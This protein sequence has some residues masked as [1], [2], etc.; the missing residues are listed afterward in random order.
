MALTNL[1]KPQ[2]DQPVFEWMRFAP[3]ATAATSALATSDDLGGRYMYYVNAQAL[4]RY[5]TYS[6][7]WQELAPPPAAPVTGTALKYSKYSGYRGH[8]ISATSNTITLAGF[9]RHAHIPDELKIRIIAGKGAGQERTITE[10]ADAVVA[11]FGL[12]TTASATTIGD[13]TK[14]WKINQWDSYQCRLVYSTGQS[15]IR[16]VLYNDTTTLYFSDTNFQAID[17][18]NNTGFSSVSP[19]AIPVTTAGSQ[20]HF[21]IESTT[22]TIDTA[23][24]VT[25]DQSSIY[26][27]ISGGLWLFS[28]SAGAPFS[29]MQF[30]D[31]LTDTWMTKTPIG[32]HLTAAYG[33]DFSMDRTGEV[34]GAFVSGVTATSAT[35]R[36]LINTG[37][38]M[39]IDRYANH[40]LR[41]V[42]GTGV[43]QRR[44]IVGHGA[45]AMY[46]ERDWDITPDSTS[47]YAIYGD[48]DKI[49]LVGNASS[50]VFGYSIEGDIW[51]N[52]H[53]S[54]WGIA[55]N[56]N[57][58]P[59]AGASYGTPHPGF[60][61]SSIVRTTSGILSGSI[62]AAGT[63]Y[64][65]GDLVTCSTTGTNGQ[66]WVTGVG[67]GGAVTSLEL[68]ASGS[69]YANGSSN[70]TGGS[71]SGLT[72]TLTVG[73]TALVTTATNHDFRTGGGE[74][75]KIAGCATDTSFNTT[76]TIIGVGSLTTFSIA[77]PSSSASPTA[78]NSQSTTL[79]VDAEK[80]W[81][82]NEHT[83]KLVIIQVAGTSPTTQVRRITSNTANTLTVPSIT[84]ATNGT[85][86]YVIQEVRGFGAMCT[87]KIANKAAFGWATSGTATTL[88]DSTKNWNIN[89]Y[90]N[91]KVRIVSGTG[92]G[93]ESTI[94]GNTAT[95]LTVA[96]WG[97]ATP[98]STSKYEILE[99][100]G[101]V[102]TGGSAVATITDANKNW[103]TNILAGKRVRVVAGTGIG[104]E[105]AI[106]SNTA[107]V[108]TCAST[109]TTD[110]T[111]VYEIYEIPARSTG[112]KVDWLFGLSDNAKKGRWLL[113]PRGG[114]SNIFDIYDI[115]SNTWEITPFF[116]PISTTLT[117]GSMY[118]YNG[119]D[120]YYFTKDNTGRLYN[121]NLNTFKIDAAGLTPYA[122]GTAVIGNRMEVVETADG[123]E[124]IYVM[125]HSGFEMWRTLRFW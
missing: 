50:C 68:A 125:R 98:D 28:S 34:G 89:Q 22:C 41:I 48:T 54:D 117:T 1:L 58:T 74:V 112:T 7:S 11:D 5:D 2:V 100:Y 52:G 12:A 114:A 79:L 43:G 39:E 37:A 8:I 62:N 106:T 29:T 108:I 93:N 47:G 92:I 118:T 57:A 30:Y 77:A 65:V 99:T 31:I 101:V 40:Q 76:F 111:T 10:V 4:W 85:G 42:S 94:T 84:A 44:R 20:T 14:K 24:D 82:V 109:L 123:L 110:T 51:S 35:A 75:V 102:T 9:S 96:S 56:I 3:V 83:G 67:S 105:L 32:G 73:T 104:T 21:L 18:F 27:I 78:A 115:P 97:V 81:Q 103:T 55:R 64:V 15:Q 91:C 38:T 61:V 60:G 13:S 6:D 113:S 80:T 124:Y 95:T 120:N 88:V 23:W 90:I 49:W 16:K 71:G 63:N 59:Y 25:P 119:G 36:T 17:H 33:T 26:Q 53:I 66:F 69:G 72:I 70:T 122:H 19:Y 116:T 46:V 107:T 86:R 87:N 45:T 121:L